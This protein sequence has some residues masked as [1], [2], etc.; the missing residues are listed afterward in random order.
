MRFSYRPF[1]MMLVLMMS[2]TGMTLLPCQAQVSASEDDSG[3][4]EQTPFVIEGNG[5]MAGKAWANGWP[6]DGTPARPYLID[7]LI[8]H[9]EA[10]ASAVDIRNTTLSFRISNCAMIALGQDGASLIYRGAGVSLTN[11]ANGSLSHLTVN[12]FVFGMDVR[13]SRD[14]R[15]DNCSVFNS[16]AVE[17][18]ILYSHR[19]TIENN[20]VRGANGS[21]IQLESSGRAIIQC[22]NASF[23]DYCGINL[24]GNSNDCLI[25][26][27]LASR[28][29]YY[30]STS[31][32]SALHLSG[33]GHHIYGNVLVGAGG[34][35]P[36]AGTGG[37]NGSQWNSSNGYGNYYGANYDPKVGSYTSFL[38]E[39]LCSQTDYNK[40]GISDKEY[41]IRNFGS[42][43]DRSSVDK[44]PLISPSS[45]PR[46]LR[47]SISDGIVTLSWEAPLFTTFP[48][49]DYIVIRNDGQSTEEVRVAGR[50]YMENTAG[51]DDWSSISY[52]VSWVGK[53]VTSG[54]SAPVSVQHPDRPSLTIVSNLDTS[55]VTLFNLTQLV[56][57]SL[58]PRSVTVE[59][60]GYDSDSDSMSYIIRLDDGKWLDNGNLQQ[61]TLTNLSEGTHTV[62][63][64]ATDNNGNQ[65]EVSKTFE[66]YRYIEMSL[67]CRPYADGSTTR[68]RLDGRAWD[69]ATGIGMADL[70]ISVA[71]SIDR[72]TSWA[73]GAVTSGTD[74]QFEFAIGLE[75]EVIHGLMFTAEIRDLNNEVHYFIEEGSYAAVIPQGQN[76]LFMVYSERTI[77]D[78]SFS[79][80]M[81][82]F[83]VSAGSDESGF[84]TILVPKDASGESDDI[85][86]IMD[87]A[88]YDYEV[89]EDGDYWVLSINHNASYHE[90]TIEIGSSGLELVSPGDLPLF[91]AGAIGI[92]IIAGITVLVW[93]SRRGGGHP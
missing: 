24:G 61:L 2:V 13:S 75:T 66:V 68:L 16:N 93:R 53:Y 40:D 55:Q 43:S 37:A 19:L 10:N 82:K 85:S 74:G 45:P 32:G 31:V 36:P 3:L 77:S 86:V 54:P 50:Q 49:D 6:G 18:Y 35:S 15:I 91:A 17:I 27:N 29:G 89:S 56:Y 73:F 38:G 46:D 20:T 1:A 67:A 76:H 33:S 71:Y 52:T 48:T 84:T 44:H 72:G 5:D 12:G 42:Y 78:L 8:F 9:S 60:R 28:N 83:N 79:S 65:V 64:R 80:R 81:M 51:L 90:V 57:S 4:K 14:I 70:P 7:G 23:N 47:A 21:G 26:W 88:R 34:P 69:A 39:P 30:G 87:G 58:D 63:I 11:V 22:N 62:T 25:R 92:A 41:I 59:W